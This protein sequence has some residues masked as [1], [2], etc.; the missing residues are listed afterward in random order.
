[1]MRATA[2]GV[3]LRAWSEGRQKGNSEGR[4]KGNSEG[5]QKGNGEGR[6]KGNSEIKSEGRQK[7]N[8]EV[9][10]WRQAQPASF[11]HHSPSGEQESVL[12]KAL[13]YFWAGLPPDAGQY[14]CKSSGGPLT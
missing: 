6:Q 5:R 9:K 12:A 8:S 13:F 14:P 7:G 10:S 1:M 2:V 4:Q 3:M 11:P